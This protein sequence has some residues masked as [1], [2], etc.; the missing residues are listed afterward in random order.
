[1]KSALGIFVLAV[2]SGV[3]AA[4][5]NLSQIPLEIPQGTPPNIMIIM[6]DSL[7]M[8]LELMTKDPDDYGGRLNSDSNQPDGTKNNDSGNITLTSGC[9]SGIVSYVVQFLINSNTF[10]GNNKCYIA[11]EN[12]WRARSNAFNPLYYDPTKTYKPWPGLSSYTK[13]G[14]RV[15]YSELIATFSADEGATG[16]VGL[17]DPY[18]PSEWID[19]ET[20][21]PYKTSGS[22]PASPDGKGFRWYTW[23]DT[24]GDDYF[25]NT[26]DTITEFLVKDQTDTVKK[27]F[28]NWFTFYRSR[29]LAAKASMAFV[30]Q[31]TVA[32]RVGYTSIGSSSYDEVVD[33]MNPSIYS[34]A[35]LEVMD[36]LAK[37]EPSGRTP[38]RTALQD[39]GQYYMCDSDSSIDFVTC[40]ILPSTDGGACQQNYALMFSDGFW[41]ETTGQTNYEP[42]A[43]G[44]QDSDTTNDYD[45]GAFADTYENTL[46]DV[47]M[48]YY[49]NDLSTTLDNLVPVSTTDK[50]RSSYLKDNDVETM[51]QH[52]TTYTVA[53]GLDA[54]DFNADTI[55]AL[56]PDATYS[57]WEDPFASDIYKVQ[58]MLHAAY[59]GRGYFYAADDY[60]TLASNLKA[61]FAAILSEQSGSAGISFNSQ[62]LSTGNVVFRA[63]YKPA[64]YS[65]DLT[66]IAI[67]SSTF[68]LGDTL[69]SASDKMVTRIKNNQD[70]IVI[71]Y[72]P[73]AKEGIN[74]DY[75]NG[76][77]ADQQALLEA[78]YP[79]NLPT[80]YGDDDGAIGDERIAYLLGD[81]SNEGDVFDDGDFREREQEDQ[82][83]QSNV[84]LAP[85]GDFA[86]STPR[87]VGRPVANHKD[88]I[89]Y[90][91]GDDAYSTFKESQ[92]NRKP[93]VY[94]GANDGMLHAFEVGVS[95]TTNDD[96]DVVQE[97]DGNGGKEAFAYVPNLVMDRLYKLTKPGYTHEMY[98]DGTPTINDVFIT[99]NSSKQWR[100]VLMA[101]L[102][103]GG[104]GYYALDVTN[105]GT[106]TES[107]AADNVMWEFTSADDDRLGYTYSTPTLVMSNAQYSDNTTHR[108]IALFGNGYNQ[109]NTDGES[110]LFAMF[111]DG[112]LDGTWTHTAGNDSDD[113]YIV[114][115]T[116][117]G[118]VTMYGETVP[119]GLGI[120]RAVDRDGNGTVDYV[121]AGDL[122]GKLYRF[123]LTSS[124]PADWSMTETL[125][126]AVDGDSTTQPITVQP[127]ADLNDTNDGLIILVPTGSWYTEEDVT[128]ESVQ[129]L[130]GVWDTFSTSTSYPVDRSVLVEQSFTTQTNQIN[131]TTVRTLSDNTVSYQATG[132][133]RK[134]GWYIDF[135]ICP[136]GTATCT[137]PEYPGER[138]IRNLLIRDGTV[139][140]VTILPTSNAACSIISGGWIF[141]INSQ[142]GGVPKQ[143]IAFDLSG[144]GDYGSEDT[145][146]DDE[147]YSA[148]EL[149]S[150]VRIEGG[151]PSEIAIVTPPGQTDSSICFQTSDGKLICE[152]VNT[153]AGFPTGRLSWKE[154]VKH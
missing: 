121:Y 32:A 16:L 106:F 2:S 151:I 71:S 89:P 107:G 117:Q 133:N 25:D 136:A 103:G 12:S 21:A 126:T 28:Q 86:N 98:V 119:N 48:Y 27:N 130:Y 65:G 139:F 61:S 35:K 59:N 83:S 150:M 7:S 116:G 1:M 122:A 92:A 115:E 114:M 10:G 93:L 134:L 137:D 74:F 100:T 95:F 40:P 44:N 70:R 146:S 8:E 84:L 118:P 19:L 94:V 76:L 29:A 153:S 38:L 124:D 77:T 112:G 79:T 11:A 97:A 36:Q 78:D 24:N 33:T 60:A 45:G 147:E 143:K 53:F 23:E 68:A 46:A 14:E 20:K 30:L 3:L 39:V 34:G 51:H 4:E 87:F 80:G 9:T 22:F 5:Q 91:T 49:K 82:A 148:G 144:D 138:A 123:D 127:I 145:F 6:D 18:D 64:T 62:E 140:G 52:M 110:A 129:S 105:P 88:Y 102:R 75:D 56:D 154:L 99:K 125:L 152:G 58:D 66:A 111:I 135:D 31:G 120:P 96:G 90:P 101:G 41:S 69:W 104:K 81:N 109:T 37:T 63:F 47:A 26:G 42:D 57:G 132:T 43:I 85:L 141:A 149:P 15:P 55:Y 142:S 73:V 17:D 128:D 113:D 50:A 72:D 108:W 131:G 67:N 54:T 13:N